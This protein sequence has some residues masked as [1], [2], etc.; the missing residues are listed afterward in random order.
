MPHGGLHG[1]IYFDLKPGAL[2]NPS[3]TIRANLGALPGGIA[4]VVVVSHV[5][6]VAPGAGP[7]PPGTTGIHIEVECVG[8]NRANAKAALWALANA[9]GAHGPNQVQNPVVWC[10]ISDF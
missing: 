1:F 6:R 10:C 5:E 8:M 4:N 9:I 2:A 3:Q 7:Q